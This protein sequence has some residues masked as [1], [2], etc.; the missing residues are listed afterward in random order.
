[1]EE[2]ESQFATLFNVERANFVIVDRF[3]KD[4]IKYSFDEH[5]NED[6][7]KTFGLDKGLAG[8]VA[9]SGHTLFVENIEDDSRFYSYLDDPKGV[10]G[11]SYFSSSYLDS[12][13]RKV[14]TFYSCVLPE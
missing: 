13:K 12:A 10:Y 9:I 14:S 11:K 1:M 7:I 5:K 4:L 3:R 2:V 6:N 8:Y